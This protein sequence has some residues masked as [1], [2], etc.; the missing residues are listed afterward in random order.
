MEP[1]TVVV[2][3]DSHGKLIG[4]GSFRPKPLPGSERV[5]ASFAKNGNARALFRRHGFEELPYTG[6]G[7]IA[8]SRS[9]RRSKAFNSGSARLARGLRRLFGKA[10]VPPPAAATTYGATPP[11]PA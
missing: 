2:L 9:A 10:T 5:A 1:Q 6:E 4:V 3:E 7:D 8:Y 11:R